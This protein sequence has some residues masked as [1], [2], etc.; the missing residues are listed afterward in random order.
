MHLSPCNYEKSIRYFD[1]L[2]SRLKNLTHDLSSSIHFTSPSLRKEFR[3]FSLRSFILRTNQDPIP[4]IFRIDRDP[5]PPEEIAQQTKRQHASSLIRPINCRSFFLSLSFLPRQQR[6][7]LCNY[8][9]SC[10]IMRTVDRR[11]WAKPSAI[12]SSLFI[13][14]RR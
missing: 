7:R 2:K 13:I 5:P 12:F 3:P 8:P 10:I 1:S 11:K 14:I 4:R 9:R 6:T